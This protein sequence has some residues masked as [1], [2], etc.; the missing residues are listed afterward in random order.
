MNYS[1]LAWLMLFYVYCFFGWVFECTVVSVEKRKPINR[2]FLRGPMLPIYGFGAIIMLHTALPLA[3]RPVA[4][5]FA[6]MVTATAFEYVVGVGMESIFKVKYWD[7]STHRFQFQGRICLTSSLAWGGLSVLMIYV[8]HPPIAYLLQEFAPL[9]LIFTASIL[10]TYFLI[11]VA[12][13]VNTALNFTKLLEELHTMRQDVHDLREQLST[14]VAEKLDIPTTAIQESREHL[15]AARAQL[16]HTI[17]EA[18]K[19]ITEK[20]HSMERGGKGL[21]RGNPTLHSA[22][23]T[24]ALLEI[25]ERLK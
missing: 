5:F 9:P 4:I 21:V 20:I 12:S 23:F 13:S 14:V 8:L 16:H 18:E 3:G 7:Y 17:G 6:G 22:R 10:S 24:E 25:R 2:G 15:R 19:Q 1:L 11:D